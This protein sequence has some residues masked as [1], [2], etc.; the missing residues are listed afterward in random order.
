LQESAASENNLQRG[1]RAKVVLFREFLQAGLFFRALLF[2]LLD[3]SAQ[4]A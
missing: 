4:T 3:G 1:R 2:S